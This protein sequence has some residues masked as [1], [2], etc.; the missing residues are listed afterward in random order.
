LTLLE[1]KKDPSR[2]L[3]VT[4]EI[5]LWH[6]AADDP[7]ARPP[8]CVVDDKVVPMSI[9]TSDTHAPAG[10]KLNAKF[11]KLVKAVLY[12]AFPSAFPQVTQV[13]DSIVF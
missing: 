10:I 2:K 3:D 12:C 5:L 8:L 9:P 7:D 4:V 1:W 11:K 6:F 13:S